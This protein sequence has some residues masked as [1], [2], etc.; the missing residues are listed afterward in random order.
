MVPISRAL[1]LAVALLAYPLAGA[2]A[3]PP[4]GDTVSK[5]TPRRVGDLPTG[6]TGPSAVP[7]TT[8]S[9]GE[10]MDAGPTATSTGKKADAG[11]ST[12]PSAKQPR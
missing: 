5:T 3:Q 2:F 1:L 4:V 7:T 10:R 11:S 9:N 6:A 8:K 12:G